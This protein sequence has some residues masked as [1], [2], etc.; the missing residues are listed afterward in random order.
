MSAPRENVLPTD[1]EERKRRPIVTGV[2]DYFSAALAEVAFVSWVGN[3]K[4]NPGEPLHWSREKSADHVDCEVRHLIDRGGS[5]EV[6]L[7]SGEVVRVRHSAERAWRAL[8]DLQLEL[9]AEGAPLARGARRP[10]PEPKPKPEPLCTHNAACGC[11]D[12]L[13]RA[14]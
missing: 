3:Q 4:H 10:E 7:P 11:P 6:K 2:L 9:E 5:D 13:G 14:R 12:A 1:S 8:A